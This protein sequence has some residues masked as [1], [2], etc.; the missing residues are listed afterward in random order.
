MCI[1]HT[2]DAQPLLPAD[3]LLQM[4]Y[5]YTMVCSGCAY[6]IPFPTLESFPMLLML[7]EL[8]GE[9]AK[10]C[11]DY[12]IHRYHCPHEAA[13]AAEVGSGSCPGRNARRYV[14]IY[15]FIYSGVN[16]YAHATVVEVRGF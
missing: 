7:W 2:D 3:L 11:D 14:Y 12:G 1:L 9:S 13:R 8:E 5:P 15:S 10:N 16:I 4:I 6:F